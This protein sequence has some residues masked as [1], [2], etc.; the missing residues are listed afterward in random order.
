MR[1]NYAIAKLNKLALLSI[2]IKKI[3]RSDS[4]NLQ[5]SIFNSG[6]GVIS[7]WLFVIVIG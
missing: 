7:Y 5:S 2:K 1:K 6:L 3:E 4:T